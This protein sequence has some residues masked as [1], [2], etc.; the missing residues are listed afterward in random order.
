MLDSPLAYMAVFGLCLI[1]GFIGVNFGGSMLLVMP[2]VIGLGWPPLVALV[3]SRPAIVGQ[4]M[5]GLYCFRRFRSIGVRE[6]LLLVAGAASGALV[7]LTV[8]AGLPINASRYVVL[9]LIVLLCLLAMAQRS[10][11]DRLSNDTAYASEPPGTI[12]LL[13]TGFVPAIIGGIVGTGAGLVVVASC[14]LLL[15]MRLENAAYAEK[16]VSMTHSLTT[17]LVSVSL[18]RLDMMLGVVMFVGVTI[19]AYSGARVTLRLNTR[20]LY[21][22][23]LLVCLLVALHFVGN[24]T[25]LARN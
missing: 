19:G 7:G 16:V 5:T 12:P 15:R 20:W 22:T 11:F 9:S 23:V 8:L 10:L 21:F 6:H 4:S 18:Q 24:G 13:L 25:G 3:S 14:L 17:L 2:A 1:G